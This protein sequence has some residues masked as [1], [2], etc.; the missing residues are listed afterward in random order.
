M[1]V[2]AL[3]LA[4][5]GSLRMGAD[6]ATLPFKGEPLWARQFRSLRELQPEAL[7]LSARVPP[8]WRPPDVEFVADEPPSRGPLSGVAAALRRLPTSHLL[9]LAV[10]LPRMTPDHLRKLCALA[11]PGCGVIPQRGGLFEPLCALYPVE[12]ASAAQSALAGHDVS[13]Q[14]FAKVLLEHNQLQIH[15]LSPTEEPLYRNVNT[16]AD[17]REGGK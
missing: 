7:W 14:H 4:G 5:G 2:T 9:V 1:N 10:D 11:R 3:L 12:A 6:K 8:A 15:P 13:L 17:L 16:P